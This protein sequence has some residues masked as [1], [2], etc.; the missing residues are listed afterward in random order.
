MAREE[1]R[2]RIREPHLPEVILNFLVGSWEKVLVSVHAKV[3]ESGN[4]WVRAIETMD[5]LTWSVAPKREPDDRKK[6]VGLLP[7]LLKRLQ[8]GMALVGLPEAERDQ[9][10]AKLMRCHA[11]AVKLGLQ[12]ASEEAAAQTAFVIQAFEAEDLARLAEGAMAEV[13]NVE[14]KEIALPEEAVA[15]DQSIVQGI[16]APLDDEVD[17]GWQT[18]TIG[19]VRWQ[20]TGGPEGDDY[21]AMVRRLKRGTWIEFEHDAGEMTRVKLAWV[22]PLR[23]LF[24]FTNRLGERAVSITPAGLATKFRAGQAQVIDNIALV[25]RAVNSLMER[26]RGTALLP[27]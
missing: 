12:P 14:F 21:D 25:D 2:R 4:L 16:A 17:S 8:Q 13:G 26:L 19:D 22:S 7:G 15:L 6:L 23:G 24:L 1:I 27:V 10:F 20:G 9:F 18:L 3:G 11:D 5:D